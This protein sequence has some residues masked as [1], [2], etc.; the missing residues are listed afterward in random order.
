MERS[1]RLHA[2]EVRGIRDGRQTQIRRAMA[3]QPECQPRVGLY[4]PT[5]V[6]RHGE[7]YPG[8]EQFGAFD[9]DG[10]WS[11][12]CPFHFKQWGEWYPNKAAGGD[13][14]IVRRGERAPDSHNWQ[15]PFYASF[16]IGKNNA[17]RMLDGRE[18]DEF[19]KVGA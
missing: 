7:Q 11:L 6:N 18:W 4:E 13:A 14:E 8:A 17:G 1:I 9:D 16:R 15:E 2:H 12:K 19:P 10:E 5:K 3:C